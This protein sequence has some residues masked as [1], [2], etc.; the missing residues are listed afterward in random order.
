MCMVVPCGADWNRPAERRAPRFGITHISYVLPAGS[1]GKL[2]ATSKTPMR[3]IT[4]KLPPGIAGWPC[5]NVTCR[6]SG[7]FRNVNACSS[8]LRPATACCRVKYALVNSRSEVRFSRLS[9]SVTINEQAAAR[10]PGPLFP[11]RL[12]RRPEPSLDAFQRL[13]HALGHLGLRKPLVVSQLYHCFLV[14]SQLLK[15]ILESRRA[16]SSDNARSSKSQ[17]WPGCAS[18][19]RSSARADTVPS[20]ERKE[21]M[22]RLRATVSTQGPSAPRSGSNACTRFHTCRKVSCTR[23]S[24]AAE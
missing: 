5:P 8:R 9:H 1:T 20:A 11:Q 10:R 4:K 6:V 14:R 23:S 21:S 18:R 7:W 13:L 2:E 3:G 15:G 19:S 16:R 17:N 12:Q 22:A 24:A